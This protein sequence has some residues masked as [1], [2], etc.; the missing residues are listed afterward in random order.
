MKKLKICIIAMLMLLLIL[1][2]SVF[3]AGSIKPSTSSLTIT[4]GST[5]TFKVTASN[6]CGRV[7]I[8]SSNSSVAKVN[9]SNKWLENSSVTVTVTGV[10]AGTAKIIVK[11]T[12][13]ATFDEEALTGSYTINVTVKDKEVTSSNNSGSNSNSNTNTNKNLS[14]N[15]KIKELSVEGYTLKDTGNNTYELTVEN[16]VQSINIAGKAEDSKATVSGTGKK[17]LKFGENKFVVT[18]KAESGAKKDYTIK[19]IRNNGFYL[20]DLNTV[21]NDGNNNNNIITIKKGDNISK[22]VFNT[23]KQSKQRVTFNYYNDKDQLEFSWV[24]DETNNEVTGETN[25]QLSQEDN[26]SAK[27]INTVVYTVIGIVT[28]AIVGMGIGFVVTRKRIK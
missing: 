26:S 28:T 23:I 27:N 10:S 21:L 12:D 4:K 20:K 18:V 6:A 7:D 22:E 19:V 14:T 17:D 8:S 9:V 15:N 24:I 13:A 1:P 5:K 2:I 25:T 16:N 11:L 3:A